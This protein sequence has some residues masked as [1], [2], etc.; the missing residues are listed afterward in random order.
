MMGLPK[1][2]FDLGSTI[3]E[4]LG[5]LRSVDKKLGALLEIERAKMKDREPRGS[6]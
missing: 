4:F 1:L 3:T 5:L 6:Q 2:D